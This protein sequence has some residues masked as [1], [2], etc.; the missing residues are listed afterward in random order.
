MTVEITRH[1]YPEEKPPSI[2]LHGE[3]D[4][5]IPYFVVIIGNQVVPLIWHAMQGRPGAWDSLV[6][7]PYHGKVFYWFDNPP[8]PTS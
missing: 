6:G 2:F 8:A 5:R 7:K 4:S 3:C 1:A